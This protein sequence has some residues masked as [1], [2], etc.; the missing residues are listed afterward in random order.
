MMSVCPVCGWDSLKTPPYG[1]TG[2]LPAY[3]ICSCCGFE[4]GFDDNGFTGSE[5]NPAHVSYRK[6]WI[7]R[8]CPWFAEAAKPAGWQAERQLE[9]IAPTS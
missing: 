6:L 5:A 3:E 9:R 8:G 1:P 7:E 2:N 4:F